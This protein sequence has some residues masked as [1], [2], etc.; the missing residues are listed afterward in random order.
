MASEASKTTLFLKWSKA[1]MNKTF[2]AE[3]KI[4]KKEYIPF[5]A[6]KDHQEIA[7][8]R[9]KHG[10]FNH[11][12]A[13]TSYS[14]L[15]FD[16]FQMFQQEAYVVIFWNVKRGDKRM[17]IIPIDE[18]MREKES[19]SRKSLTYERSCELGVCEIL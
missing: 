6:V 4:T 1:R 3:C 13:D 10:I 11:K 18:W 5:D 7:L 17:T 12:I 14:Q 2:V 8:Y 9:V 16:L 15:P 19:S